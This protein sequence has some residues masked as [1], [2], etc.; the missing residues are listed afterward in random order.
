[1]TQPES[2]VSTAFRRAT[3][4]PD[5]AV[6]F[7]SVARRVHRRHRIAA[8]SSTMVAVVVV[9]ALAGVGNQM[10]RSTGHNSPL[11]GASPSAVAPATTRV[12][13]SGQLRLTGGASTASEHGT[14]GKVYFLA[15]DGT[16]TTVGAAS[17]G[18]FSVRLKPGEYTAT[19]TSFSYGD[20]NYLCR[21]RN[22]VT[23]SAGSPIFVL[24]AC[25]RR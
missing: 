23:V 25:D 3:A 5:G 11:R 15:G 7:E 17:D 21:A 9:A 1:M 19:G 24:V 2:T 16:K 14:A 8:A 12:P 10:F 13:V 6:S 22:P 20:G 18:A 4:V